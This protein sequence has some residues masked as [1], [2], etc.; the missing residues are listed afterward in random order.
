MKRILLMIIMTIVL[1][2]PTV[3]AFATSNSD[4]NAEAISSVK[5]MQSDEVKKITVQFHD[6]EKKISNKYRVESLK[7]LFNSKY[8]IRTPKKDAGKGWIYTIRGKSK[9]GKVISKITIV[10]AKHISIS[11]KT[12]KVAKLNLKKFRY[13]FKNGN[14]T[15]I[16]SSKKIRSV[17]IQFQGKYKNIKNK[18]VEKNIFTCKDC[19]DKK[20]CRQRLDI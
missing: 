14:K 18:K 16:F 15:P 20:Y 11:G 3:A 1:I 7:K 9:N 6:K 8:Y 5:K 12:Y 13:Y 10:D 19:A 2:I 4:D 17:N